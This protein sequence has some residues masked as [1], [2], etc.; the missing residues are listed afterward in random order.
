[1]DKKN[2][3]TL[4]ILCGSL[5]YF[6]CSEDTAQFEWRQVKSDTNTHLYGVHFVDAKHGWAVGTAGTVL[7]TTDGGTTWIADPLSLKTH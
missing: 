4:I 3:L 2:Y 5:V 1:M 6:G 7:S